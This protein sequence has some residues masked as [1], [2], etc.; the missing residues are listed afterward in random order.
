MKSKKI[1]LSVLFIV[2]YYVVHS[3]A[4]TSTP[5]TGGPKDTIPPVLIKVL[6]D[7]NSVNFPVK[8]GT[9]EMKFDEYVVL[10]EPNKFVYL[11]PP[12]KKRLTTK[13]RGKSIF[14][15]FPEI[16]DSSATYSLHFGTSIND[17][18]EGNVFYP[19]VYSFSTGK[20]VDSM[21]YAGV[22][23]DSR[24]L[25][26]MEDIVVGFYSNLSD[27]AIYKNYPSVLAKSDK[28]GYYVGMNLKPIPYRL[29]AFKDINNNN[30][31]DPENE[32]ISF[33]DSLVVPTKVMAKESEELRFVDMKDTSKALARPFQTEMYLFREASQKQY[34]KDKK[35]PQRKMAFVTFAAPYVKIDSMGFRGYDSTQII[36]QFN[37]T[38]DSLVLWIKDSLIVSDTLMFDI[39]YYKSDSLSNLVVSRESLM[40]VAPKTV[41][42]APPARRTPGTTDIKPPRTDLLKLAIEAKPDMIEQEGFKLIFP[43]PFISIKHDSVTLFSK[44]PK[45][46]LAKEPFIFTQDSL[47]TRFYYVKPN[48]KMLQG[49]EYILRIAEGTFK[50]VYKFTNDSSRTN[51]M[52]PNSDKL[53]RLT[54]NIS[55]ADGSYLIEL[56]NQTR[57]KVYRGFKI[58]HD[59]KLEFPYIQP[60][61][62]NI[63][64]TQDLNGNGILDTGNLPLKKQPEKVRLY[65]LK[66]GSS[67]LVFKEG[68]D[69]EQNI[70]LKEFFK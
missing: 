55:G 50:D 3:C 47:E 7:S 27:T 49:Y 13:I 6:P 19:Y 32:M 24:T 21:M 64:I 56:T 20:S 60:G 1:Q 65:L 38:R 8:G 37:I 41:K 52:L 57:D 23:M 42:Q 28:W 48:I 10:K 53:S 9:I 69:L 34:I 66:S 62:Y 54:L 46:I 58:T 35:R 63:R 67:E 51:V 12:Q 44:T 29:Y 5:P 18:N 16:L 61:K 33:C 22:I 30:H 4:N 14:V 31:Y 17:N 40:L 39:K 11:S 59:T 45:G 36:K 26:P 43:A 2:L 68:L 15:T 25:L 70:N